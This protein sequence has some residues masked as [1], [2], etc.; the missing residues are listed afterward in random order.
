VS[1]SDLAQALVESL[2]AEALDRLA[3]LLAP[4]IG[5]GSQRPEPWLDAEG[6]AEHLACT[7]RR[8]YDLVARSESNH[9][10]IHRDGRRLLFKPSELDH[11]LT[12]CH[13]T[14]VGIRPK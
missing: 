10:P 7:P 2:D 8:I 3:S 13:S 1:A 5:T 14:H 4:R 11:W 6:A 9:F 12:D